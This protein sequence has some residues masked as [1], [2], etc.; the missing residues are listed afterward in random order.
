MCL[1][2]QGEPATLVVVQRGGL[3]SSVLLSVE[4]LGDA[5]P[6]GA[7]QGGGQHDR[8]P[9]RQHHHSLPPSTDQRSRRGPQQ[10]EH[11]H[12]ALSRWLSERRELQERDL[13]L[14]QRFTALPVKIPDAPPLIA[15][16]ENLA[17]TATGM[18]SVQH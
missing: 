3:G 2:H 4:Q 11:G 17:K 16:V 14:L 18:A 13:L 15:G 9:T 5:E 8:S 1:G 6:T 12:Q 7:N 10:Q